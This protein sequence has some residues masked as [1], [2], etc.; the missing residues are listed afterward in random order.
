MPTINYI[1]KCGV[2]MMNINGKDNTAINDNNEPYVCFK[3]PVTIHKVMMIRYDYCNYIPTLKTSNSICLGR[4][5]TEQAAEDY[6]NK[7]CED[8]NNNL[9]R[10]RMYIEKEFI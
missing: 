2:N 9:L 5:L 4:F 3:G 6:I 7:A 8:T 10:C 1:K